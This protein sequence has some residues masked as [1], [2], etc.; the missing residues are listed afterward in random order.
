MTAFTPSPELRFVFRAADPRCRAEE[1][2]ALLPQIQDWQRVARLAE[3]EGATG[4]LWRT[5][6]PVIEQVPMEFV[7]FL[8]ARTMLADFRMQRLA[9][10]AQET[11][12]AL[13]AA[14]IPVLLLKGAAVGALHDPTF[15]Q[16][17]MTDVDFLIHEA[18]AERARNCVRAAGWREMPEPRLQDLL[19]GHQHLPPFVDPTLEG[20]RLEL[21]TRLLPADSSFA[22]T[23]E[24]LWAASSVAPPPFSMARVPDAARLLI[25]TAVHFAWQHEMRFGPWR[26]FRSVALLVQAPGWQWSAFVEMARAA[27]AATSCYWTLRMSQLLC[28]IE[29]PRDALQR[30]APPTIEPLRRVLDRHFAAMADPNERPP[31][32]SD[33]LSSLLWRLALRPRW[34]GH[35]S[36]SRVDPERRW[37]RAFNVEGQDVGLARVRRHVDARK[38][39]WEFFRR[40]I[41]GR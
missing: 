32:P 10:R 4:V 11:A 2:L 1:L 31:S 28:G 41:A 7:R 17:P 13:K 34:S 16:R 26:T 9:T 5:L 30:L 15:R 3:A 38:A 6:R 8:Q 23:S 19:Q 33:R 22:L 36:V 24:S 35:A 29:I 27:R 37:E 40:T 14:G 18:D 25:H 20:M 12:E 21:H 39:W